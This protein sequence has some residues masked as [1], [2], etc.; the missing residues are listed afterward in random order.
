[1]N[2]LKLI[3]WISKN[4]ISPSV[5]PTTCLLVNKMVLDVYFAQIRYEAS[6]VQ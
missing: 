1:M 2:T 5:S 4:I 6:M 3:T